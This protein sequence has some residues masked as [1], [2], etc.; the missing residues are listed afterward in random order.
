VKGKT[1][2]VR[3]LDPTLADATACH[4][5]VAAKDV[6]PWVNLHHHQRPTVTIWTTSTV[7][8]KS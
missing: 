6:K 5:R 1:P 3:S 7:G 4:L 8:V 2:L